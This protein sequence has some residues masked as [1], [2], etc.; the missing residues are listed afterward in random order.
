VYSPG[1]V[2]NHRK[3]QY[4]GLFDMPFPEKFRAL[5]EL[6]EGQVTTPDYVW[7]SY[8]VEGKNILLPIL[9]TILQSG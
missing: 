7:L 1:F 4:H 2:N 6:H 9:P 3:P 8:G 5:V